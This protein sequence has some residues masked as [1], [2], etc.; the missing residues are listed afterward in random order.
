MPTRSESSI[1]RSV[2]QYAREK[3][4]IAIKLTTAGSFGSVGWPDYMFVAWEGAVFMVEFKAPGG[5]PT[6][7]QRKCHELLLQHGIQVSVVDEVARGK[8]LVD[9]WCQHETD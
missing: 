9:R 2:V 1:Q 5:Q 7:R 8:W 6:E 4:L 3:G